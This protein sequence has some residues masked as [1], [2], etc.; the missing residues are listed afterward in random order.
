M[1]G[2]SWRLGRIA[3]IEVRIDSS[4]VVIALLIIY[5]M[6]R[7]SALGQA[8]ARVWRFARWMA[9][10]HM[11]QPPAGATSDAI[12]LDEQLAPTSEPAWRADSSWGRASLPRRQAN[13]GQACSRAQ[14]QRRCDEAHWHQQGQHPHGD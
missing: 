5:S 6:Y 11:S 8:G 14:Q 4:W 2:T 10:C 7:L 1:F 9:P 3:G 12:G 13:Q